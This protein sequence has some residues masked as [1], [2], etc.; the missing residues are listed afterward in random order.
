MA[1]PTS[2]TYVPN[3][4]VMLKV[5]HER[6]C[7]A[8]WPAF[9]G[10]RRAI[11]TRWIALARA[12]RRRGDAASRRCARPSRT[13]SAKSSWSF[14]RRIVRTRSPSTRGRP[15][16]A[17]S[18]RAAQINACRA[19]RAAGV[20]A[21]ISPG[22]RFAPSSWWRSLTITCRARASVTPHN[23]GAFAATSPSATAPTQQLEVVPAQELAAIFG[24]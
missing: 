16:P 24:R 15:G 1:K 6:D 19:G 8:S 7:T 2:G 5:K 21:R 14:S 10:T 22:S 12:L 17:R 23:S 3:K 20:K 9:V 4:R 13:K 18:P 11:A